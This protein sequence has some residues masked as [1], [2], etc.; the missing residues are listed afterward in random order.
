M[1]EVEWMKQA[2]EEAIEQYNA[3]NIWF[4]NAVKCCKNCRYWEIE[5]GHNYAYEA[6]LFGKPRLTRW[7][8]YC[9]KYDGDA[10]VEHLIDFLHL[11]VTE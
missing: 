11:E 5:E 1:N 10:E 4:G 2:S 3:N 9:D 6:C 7:D 8:C